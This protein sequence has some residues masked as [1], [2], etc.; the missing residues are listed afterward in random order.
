MEGDRTRIMDLREGLRNVSISGRVLETGEPKMVET[1]RGPATLSEAVV[2]D[3]SGRV[4]VTLWGSHAGTLKEGEAVRIEGAWTTSYRGKVQVNVGRE[5]T[6]EKV[7]SEDVPQAEDIPEEMPEAQ[8]RGF[9]QRQP[10]RSGG[11]GGFRGGGYQPRRG[12]RR[13]F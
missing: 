5:S 9:G 7:D 12:G 13:R 4:K 2:G 8:Y 11:F 3:E 6:I 1:K 10:Y